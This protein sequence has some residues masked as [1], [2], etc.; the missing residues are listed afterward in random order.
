MMLLYR[1]FATSSPEDCN[2]GTPAMMPA[3][4]GQPLL[5]GLY[6]RRNLQ[7][8]LD[9]SRTSDMIDTDLQLRTQAG[10]ASAD[11]AS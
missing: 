8:R 5:W 7:T 1:D 4:P 11:F 10:H 2:P 3:R 6:W 9:A